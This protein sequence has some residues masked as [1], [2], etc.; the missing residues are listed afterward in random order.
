MISHATR[1]RL[2]WATN[3][4]LAVGAAAVVVWAR[5]PLDLPAPTVGPRT[6]APASAP[7]AS[8]PADPAAYAVIYTASLRR[9]LFD[10]P[11]PVVTPPPPPTLPLRLTGTIV[12]PGFTY[13][14]FR[15]AAG[16]T[17]MAKPGDVVDGV[18]VLGV[19]DSSATV[20]FGGRE[21]TLP[22]EKEA[23]GP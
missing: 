13:A 20:R 11:P 21:V 1:K 3:A 5:S 7:A 4:V 17:K 19:T 10:V 15:S 2:L 9:P 12:E 6:V 8:P 14:T 18:E 16:E 22:V 23:P